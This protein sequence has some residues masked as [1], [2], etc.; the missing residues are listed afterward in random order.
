MPRI[1]LIEKPTYSFTTN[2]TVRIDD[3]N[4]GGH[5]DNATIPV[6]L[7]EARIRYLK[8]IGSTGWDMGDGITGIV[9]G[10][11]FINYK[12][13][14]F[15]GSEIAIDCEIDEIEEKSFRMFHRIRNNGVVAILAETGL[16][17]F[18]IKEKKIGRIPEAFKEKIL[19]FK[20]SKII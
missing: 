13:E 8:E 14:I 18:N 11:L 12:A 15:Y 17:G 10:D 16:V 2:C 4:F 1:K 3:I 20:E 19:K 7:N 6:F 5:V 9:I